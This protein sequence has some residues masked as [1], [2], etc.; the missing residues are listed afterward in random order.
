MHIR[1]E[2]KA[3]LKGETFCRFLKRPLG[4]AFQKRK[5]ASPAGCNLPRVVAHHLEAR[6]RETTHDFRYTE[7][8][9]GLR[10][11]E[12]GRKKSKTFKAR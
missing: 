11:A 10:K 5:S 12:E 2:K 1:P 3:G 8:R 4:V 9:T 7:S 6:A